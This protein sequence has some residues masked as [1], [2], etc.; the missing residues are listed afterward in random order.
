M[1]LMKKENEGSVAVEIPEEFK[2]MFNLANNMEGVVPRL[3]QISIIH[4]GQMYTLPDESKV[5]EFEGIIIDQTPANA[6]WEKD[7][8]ESG[9]NAPPDCFSMNGVY[10]DEGCNLQQNDECAGC[11]QN[12]FGSDKN[13][14]GKACKNMKRVHI[15]MEDSSL[16][17]RLTIPP[18]S[19]RSFDNYMTE[20]V[21]R[22]LPYG[23]VVSKFTL[24]K[25][26]S[27]SFEFSEV[28][29]NFVRV[30][31]QNEIAIV[32]DTIK[33]FRDTARKQEIRADEYAAPDSNNETENKNQKQ[34]DD[35]IPF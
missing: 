10:P 13:G 3:P 22:G 17:R 4:R 26:T 24:A 1:E 11:K 21:D 15:L 32:A 35:D 9:G 27:E 34:P 30:L 29:I 14:K 31:N 2:G 23:C 16:P 6:W 12:Q 19:I 8:S 28:K 25:K 5:Q 7:I 18:T 33:K 20:L